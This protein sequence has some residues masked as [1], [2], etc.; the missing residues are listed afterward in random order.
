MA[1]HTIG[2][3]R[4]RTYS[5]TN[6]TSNTA[7][8]FAITNRCKLIECFHAPRINQTAPAGSWTAS[9]NGTQISGLSSVAV[10]SAA[11][12]ESSVVSNAA[13][14]TE[15]FAKRGDIVSIAASSLTAC[16]WTFVVDE[17]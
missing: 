11:V 5:A 2:S 8:A 12:G 15:T 14:T 3:F 10:S 7:G 17:F 16:T 13:V 1:Y 6:V 9:L 4:R